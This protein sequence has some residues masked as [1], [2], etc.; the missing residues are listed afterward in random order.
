MKLI[1]E[2]PTELRIKIFPVRSWVSAVIFLLMALL[3]FGSCSRTSIR[4]V[5]GTK[6]NLCIINSS[7]IFGLADAH[8]EFKSSDL[9]GAKIDIK[10]RTTST[11]GDHVLV[12]IKTKNKKI[13]LTSDYVSNFAKM[14]KIVTA[15]TYFV[16]HPQQKK[17]SMSYYD[18]DNNQ[19]ILLVISIIL[20][21]ISICRKIIYIKFD[22]NKD[23]V[24]IKWFNF[25]VRN[26]YSCKLSDIAEVKSELNAR[27]RYN[28]TQDVIITKAGDKMPL[29]Y[30]GACGWFAGR[31]LA[32]RINKFLNI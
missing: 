12:I 22:K 23:L 25:F 31:S 13:P 15:I 6:Q 19:M 24:M 20:I 26:K 7:S 11:S 29:T 28:R 2:T 8:H 30:Y 1:N 32:E 4:C 5:R 10:S 18:M 27:S 9:L 21:A 17:L 16:H 14:E 3:I